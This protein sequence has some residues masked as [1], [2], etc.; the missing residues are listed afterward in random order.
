MASMEL[1]R[2][3]Q[4]KARRNQARARRAVMWVQPH[5]LLSQR[6]SSQLQV[7]WVMKVSLSTAEHD[8]Q[9]ILNKTRFRA[10]KLIQT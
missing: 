7:N 3:L 9:L 1:N 8:N 6:S 4:A 2:E 5:Q 10:F